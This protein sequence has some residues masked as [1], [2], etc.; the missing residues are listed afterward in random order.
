MDEKNLVTISLFFSLVGILI[1]IF[2]S[3]NIEPPFYK[4]SEIDKS[5]KEKTIT[6]I[7]K[8]SLLKETKDIFIFT[9]NDDFSDIIVIAFKEDNLSLEKNT[10]VKIVGKIIEYN[11]ELEIQ[12]KEIF[13]I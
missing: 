9:L 2:L 1:L 3:G 4:I 7:G 13:T 11:G 5:L 12:A 10:E 8:I 6:T